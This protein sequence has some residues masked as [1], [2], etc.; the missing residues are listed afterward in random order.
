MLYNRA[1]TIAILSFLGL[2]IACSDYLD[3]QPEDK[4]LEEQVYSNKSGINNVLNDIYLE[5]SSSSLY[6]GQLTMSTVDILAQLYDTSNS[7]HSWYNHGHYLYEEGNVKGNF[8]AIWSSAYKV[9]LNINEF[10]ENLNVYD[11]ILS[12]E[13]EDILKGEAYALRALLHFDLLRVFG[14]VY[15]ANPNDPA[16]PYNTEA[17]SEAE[18]IVEASKVMENIL[19]DLLTAEKLL[20]KDPIL[21]NGI[22]GDNDAPFFADRNYRLNYYALKAL[23]ARVYLYGGKKDEALTAAEFVIEETENLF[24]WIDPTEIMSAGETPNRLFSMEVIFAL[25]NVDLYNQ[26]KSLFSPELK[27]TTVLAPNSTRLDEVF[28]Y[29]ENDYRFNPL[30]KLPSVGLLDFRTF[31]KYEEITDTDIDISYRYMQPLI[32]ISEMYLIAAEVE[33]NQGKALEYLNTLR[34][35]R[36]LLDLKEVEDINGEIKKEYMK[37]FYGEGQLFFYYKRRNVS[38]IPDGNES[39]DMQTIEIGNDEFVIPLPESETKFQ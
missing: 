9:I 10:L 15:E 22:S 4:L 26:Y 13:E 25:Q 11:G 35:N 32:R 5:L 29:N 23:Q 3:V 27:K 1:K 39:Q 31:F 16:I 33:P 21:Y 6:G 8:D 30:W 36:G 14:P 19:N 7:D 17:K 20:D 2:F 34:F 38:A 18:P 24:P 12:N 37:E 28:E